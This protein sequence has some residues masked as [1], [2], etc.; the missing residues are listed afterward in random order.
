V[1]LGT[2]ALSAG[3]YDAY[4]VR[5]QKVRALIKRD[6]EEAFAKVDAIVSPTSP[7]TA[8]KLGEKL[9][10]PLAMYLDDVY[11]VPANLAGLPGISVPCGFD[12]KRLPIGLQLIGK[13]FDEETLLRLAAQLE[14]A[15]PWFQRYAT[16]KL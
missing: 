10:D 2:Y 4:Y 12:S 7:T 5:A 1:M 8:K 6:F 11:T 15:Q 9:D 3:Y 14:K 16:I 13:P